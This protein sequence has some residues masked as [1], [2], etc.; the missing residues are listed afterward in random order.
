ML[1]KI[2]QKVIV[3]QVLTEQSKKKL[4]T[5]FESSKLALKKECEQFRFEIKKLEKNNKYL[6]HE[7]IAQLKREIDLRLEKIKLIDFQIEQLNILPLGSEL[8]EKEVEAIVDI[9]I[10]DNWEQLTKSKTIIIR[11]GIVIDIR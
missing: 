7:M 8:K 3:K 4:H 2:L 10:G 11:D 5:S 6:R 9:K 1:V